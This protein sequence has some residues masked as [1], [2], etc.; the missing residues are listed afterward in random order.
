MAE[1]EAIRPDG[2]VSL[3]QKLY[4]VYKDKYRFE[5][6]NESNRQIDTELQ[7]KP[8]QKQKR[9]IREQLKAPRQETPQP[10]KQKKKEYER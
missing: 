9:S 6:F 3:V 10:K 8:I 2:N 4:A 5:I 1:R 7:E